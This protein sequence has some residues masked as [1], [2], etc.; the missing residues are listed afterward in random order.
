MAAQVDAANIRRTVE[1]LAGFGTRHTMS[2]T[3]S[4]VRGIGAARRWIRAEF[5]KYREAGGGRLEVEYDGFIYEPDGNRITRTTEI[6]NVV[7]TLPGSQ[8][9]SHSRIYVVSAHY[10]SICNDPKDS[11]CDA[12]GANDDA[13]GVAVVLELAR[14]M[15]VHEFDATIIFMAVAGEEQG[16]I[17]SRHWAKRA[18]ERGLNIAGM[19]TND[20]RRASRSARRRK[21][22]GCSALPGTRAIH[23]PDNWRAT[24]TNASIAT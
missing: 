10:D 6:V 5:E 7:A 21:S 3:D 12:P 19:F 22:F 11:D 13:S 18:R 17:G 2:A 1:T 20:I 23:P 9:A 16:L 4:D 24:F 8:P 14:I 15:S